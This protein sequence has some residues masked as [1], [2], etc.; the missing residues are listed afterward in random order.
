MG[1]THIFSVREEKYYKVDEDANKFK[2]FNEYG[3]GS[4]YVCIDHVL[5]KF[6]DLPLLDKF[7]RYYT[8]IWT[9]DIYLDEELIDAIIEDIDTWEYKSEE[10]YVELTP[11][12]EL[13]FFLKKLKKYM[14]K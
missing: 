6:K 9:G 14:K 8:E 1:L 4:K 10:L 13:M 3:S 2:E 5:G 11:F 12:L 7:I